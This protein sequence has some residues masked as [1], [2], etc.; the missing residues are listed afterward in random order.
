MVGY[1]T[2]ATV[3]DTL[4]GTVSNH[5]YIAGQ[6]FSAAD[7]HVG[8]H[9]A[10]GMQFGSLEAR[11]QFGAYVARITARDAY[12]RANALD[13]ASCRHGRMAPEV[14]ITH[15]RVLDPIGR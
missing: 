15:G 6:E 4:A 3:V 7:V 9:I 11:P 12:Q 10:W 5:D 8:S 1:G 2:M 13:D 14:L